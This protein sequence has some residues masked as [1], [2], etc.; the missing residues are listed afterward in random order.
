[1]SLEGASRGSRHGQRYPS[2][3]KTVASR[4][5]NVQGVLPVFYYQVFH[6]QCAKHFVSCLLTNT[7]FCPIILSIFLSQSSSRYW[8]YHDCQF[9]F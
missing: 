7:C 3:K 2:A 8:I 4:V 6:C 9:Q 5:Q 1:M